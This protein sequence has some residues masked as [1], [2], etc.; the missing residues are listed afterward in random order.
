[1]RDR[2]GRGGRLIPHAHTNT[3][4]ADICHCRWLKTIPHFTCSRA[5]TCTRNADRFLFFFI[6]ACVYAGSSSSE[7]AAEPHRGVELLFFTSKLAGFGHAH[8]RERKTAQAG[9]CALAHGGRAPNGF[10]GVTQ[11]GQAECVGGAAHQ[12]QIHLSGVVLHMRGG[13]N[14]ASVGAET[15]SV[16][17]QAT[18]TQS[19]RCGATQRSRCALSQSGG[20]G[21]AGDELRHETERNHYREPNVIVRYHAREPFKPGD[22]A[23]NV[24]SQLQDVV[25]FFFCVCLTSGAL[26]LESHAKAFARRGN[27]IYMEISL[28]PTP[29]LRSCY[30][31]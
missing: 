11:S 30:S 28:W 14:R 21:G 7:S 2:E 6:F 4:H 29:T 20:G 27:N 18:A 10:A 24:K 15:S 31:A 12:G 22:A 13:G 16:H 1:M 9:A 8:A 19:P 17:A 25:S 23:E 5:R 3:R 26:K